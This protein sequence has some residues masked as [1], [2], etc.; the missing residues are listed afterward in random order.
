MDIT[1]CKQK[2]YANCDCTN[3]IKKVNTLITNLEK[4]LRDR[5]WFLYHLKS[6]RDKYNLIKSI[7]YE[8][9]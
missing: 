9:I 2:E 3:C 8:F 7:K 6:S 5:Q 1:D 4:E